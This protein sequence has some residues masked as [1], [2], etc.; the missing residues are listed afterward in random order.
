VLLLGFAKRST[1]NLLRLGDWRRCPNSSAN[2]I[3]RL[4]GLIKICNEDDCPGIG[5]KVI[6]A[7]QESWTRRHM[8]VLRKQERAAT[9][10]G[11]K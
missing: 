7:G 5:Q 9:I 11:R 3:L 1:R 10:M 8:K 6:A 4:W 2:K